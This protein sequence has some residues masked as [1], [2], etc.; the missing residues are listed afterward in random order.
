VHMV[1]TSAFR[2]L[3]A[4]LLDRVTVHSPSNWWQDGEPLTAYMH[5]PAIV[6]RS[7]RLNDH[8]DDQSWLPSEL[9]RC[10]SKCAMAD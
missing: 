3:P 2:W 1:C 5:V 9:H 7:T 8:F 10:N 4:R 6:S